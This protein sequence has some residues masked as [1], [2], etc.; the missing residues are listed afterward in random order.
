MCEESHD[1]RQAE[2]RRD[3][4]ELFQAGANWPVRET[5][6]GAMQMS[7]KSLEFLGWR[8][9]A[10]R[11]AANKFRDYDRDLLLQQARMQIDGVEEEE[12]VARARQMMQDLESL[13]VQDATEAGKSEMQ[14]TWAEN[15]NA[16]GR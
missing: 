3:A 10:A 1:H 11:R 16:E 14:D 6:D 7:R 13:F 15:E 9:Y 8:P 12:M 5:F 2:A 4:F